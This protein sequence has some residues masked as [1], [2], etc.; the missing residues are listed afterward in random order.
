MWLRR[1]RYLDR[2]GPFQRG[3]AV[4]SLDQF[5]ARRSKQVAQYPAIILVVLDDQDALRH[6]A[7]TCRSTL[8]GSVSETVEPWPSYDSTQMRPPCISTMRLEIARPRPV[9]PF[10]RVAEFSACWNSSKIFP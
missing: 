4:V 10:L 6:A 8:T 7:P 1:A 3:L 2:R 5:V 9:P